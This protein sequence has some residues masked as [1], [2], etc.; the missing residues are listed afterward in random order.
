[1]IFRTCGTQHVFLVSV[2]CLILT[3]LWATYSNSLTT[4]R[5]FISV[6]TCQSSTILTLHLI[7]IHPFNHSHPSIFKLTQT[8]SSIPQSLP[9]IHPSLTKPSFQPYTPSFLPYMHPSPT[10]SFIYPPILPPTHP[11]FLLSI[12]PLTHF[13]IPLFHLSIHLVFHSSF[14]N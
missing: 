11:S 7:S 3:Y 5:L 2:F 8:Y 14:T 13:S 10:D 1:M 4:F 9:S 12:H 6:S